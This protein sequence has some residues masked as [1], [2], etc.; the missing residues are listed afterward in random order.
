MRLSRT[1]GTP[2][3]GC[4]V[5]QVNATE[6]K[7]LVGQQD[8]RRRSCRDLVQC[9]R[10]V[11]LGAIGKYVA[12]PACGEDVREVRVGIERHVWIPPD[13]VEDGHRGPLGGHGPCVGHQRLQL[14]KQ[15]AARS[16]TPVTSPS[17]RIIRRLSSTLRGYVTQTGIPH[18]RRVSTWARTFSSTLATTRSGARRWIC[19]RSGF[20]SPPILGLAAYHIARLHTVDGDPHQPIGQS[21]VAQELRGAGNERYDPLGRDPAANA[22]PEAST[23]VELPVTGCAGSSTARRPR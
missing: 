22:T 18:P 15:R 16:G 21:Q 1:A 3:V 12:R 8:H 9:H 5:L 7:R 13:R 20:F 4:E 6:A 19:C 14:L 17:S 2:G 11:A 23:R 10:R